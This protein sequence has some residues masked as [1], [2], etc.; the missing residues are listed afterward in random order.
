MSKVDQH[1]S[2]FLRE[3][4]NVL[5]RKIQF[6]TLTVSRKNQWLRTRTFEP[7]KPQPMP[8]SGPNK[9]KIQFF[10]ATA[11]I[12][13]LLYLVLS[14]WKMDIGWTTTPEPKQAEHLPPVPVQPQAT[15][16]RSASAQASAPLESTVYITRSG[17]RFHRSN[18]RY[19][20]LS[21]ISIDKVE[22][23]KN[24]YSACLVCQP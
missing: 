9:W 22:A 14:P 2:R 13:V 23:E 24:G 18:C 8:G 3:T 15:E 12:G 17:H 10:I 6:D 1:L 21:K 20:N 5:K 7:P 19:L 16:P 4:V 11:V